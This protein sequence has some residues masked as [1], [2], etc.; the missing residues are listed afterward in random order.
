[1]LGPLKPAPWHTPKENTIGWNTWRGGLNTLLRE[2]EIQGSELVQATNLLLVGSGV[3]TKRWGS[4]NYFLSGATGYGR[5]VF[6][7]KDAN[8]NI[9]VLALTDWGYLVKQNNA[10]YTQI[11]GGSFPSGYNV[12]AAELNAN[13]YIVNQQQ[14]WYRYNFSALVNFPTLAIPT[15]LTQTM[16][17]TA[18]GLNNISWRVT[19]LAQSGGETTAS[20]NVLASGLPADL[21]KTLIRINWTAVSA[22]SGALAGYNIYRG[23]AG[24]EVWVG[25]VNNNTQTFDDYGFPSTQLFR[26]TPPTDTSGGPQ[27]KYIIRFQDR[28]ILAGFSGDPTKVL[29]SARYPNH[30]RFDWFVQGGSIKIEPDSGED[31]TGIS[32]YYRSATSTQTIVVFKEKSVWELSLDTIAFGPYILLNPT[33]RLLTLSQGCGSHRSIQSVENDLMFVNQRGMYILRYEPQLLNVINANELSAKIRPFFLG[34]SNTDITSAAAIYADKKYVVSFPSSKQSIMYDRERL[35]FMGPWTTPFGINHW[36]KFVDASG[37]ERWLTSD[38]TDNYVSEFRTS[39]VDDKGTAMRTTFRSRKEDFGVW[40]VFKTINELYMNF[41]NVQ[42]SVN[43]NVYLE[44]RSGATILTKAFTITSASGKSGF[45]TDEF[46]LVEFGLSG[47]NP[48]V[49]STELPKKSFL[50][51]VA[52]TMQIEIITTGN[53]DNYELLAIRGVAINQSRGNSP[54]SWIV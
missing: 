6:P 51:K 42:G 5:F 44:Q 46:G 36:A 28:L 25:G 17:S 2:T 29:I 54:S 41:R 27:A 16:L 8:D 52:R 26:T 9:Q 24:G 34:L 22:T 45:G 11:T 15:G 35:C 19:A 12:E 30:E 37:I 21:T 40:E 14:A 48:A 50:Y 23:P 31:I 4:A 7:I 49:T 3:P 32:V 33:Y 39:Y 53:V 10:S 38:S 20:T 13:V 47:T 1:M 43:V 18:T